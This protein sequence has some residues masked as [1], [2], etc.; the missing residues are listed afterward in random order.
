LSLKKGSSSG[1]PLLFS[2]A[3]TFSETRRPP[4]YQG[5]HQWTIITN[6]DQRRTVGWLEKTA[7]ELKNPKKIDAAFHNDGHLAVANQAR[8]SKSEWCAPV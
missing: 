1:S 7:K 5:L 4:P 6:R 8:K 3:V 2:E